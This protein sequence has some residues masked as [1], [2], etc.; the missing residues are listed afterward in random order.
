MHLNICGMRKKKDTLEELIHKQRPD[1]LG[2]C[3][4]NLEYNTEA[5]IISEYNWYGKSGTRNKKGVGLY[6]NSKLTP[7]TEK[8]TQITE[9]SEEGRI[10]GIQIKNLAIFEC[11]APV[12]CAKE[13][14]L[15]QFF[16]DLQE[17]L[18][19]ALI[20][21]HEIIL[22][23]DFN[24]HVQGHH[25]TANN[26]NGKMLVS[27]I[28][29]SKLELLPIKDITFKGRNQSQSCIDYIAVTELA[30]INMMHTGI[31]TSVIVESDHI[32]I[33]TSI[34]VSFQTPEIKIRPKY[35][36]SLLKN[37]QK[38]QEY[39][40]KVAQHALENDITNN[41]SEKYNRLTRILKI[42]AK[43]ILGTVETNRKSKHKFDEQIK[44]Y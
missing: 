12:E 40:N 6:I 34:K 5:P 30:N 38:R 43:E 22:L 39:Q 11:Y 7:M 25:S 37:L 33:G 1:M 9:N 32:P 3:E 35:K 24:A 27:L 28:K 41:P 23:G 42:A 2:L 19:N 36:V 13:E 16:D 21:N 15:E 20:K 17:H 4:T 31:I 10:I 18:N 26:L 44:R 29:N 8:E 14:E